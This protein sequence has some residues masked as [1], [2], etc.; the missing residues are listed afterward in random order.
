MKKIMSAF[1]VAVFVGNNK[2]SNLEDFLSDFVKE[3]KV[4]RENGFNYQGHTFNIDIL[5][6]LCDA[7]A[8]QFLKC[9][10]GHTGY[11]AC[12][13]CLVEGDYVSSRVIFP[14]LNC[15]L[16]V[17]ES[18][19]N[20]EY[21]GTHQIKKTVLIDAGIN[22]VKQFPLDYMHLVC[23]GVMKRLMLSWTEG[24]RQFKLSPR[25]IKQ[26]S[27]KLESFKGKL[28]TDFVR[29]PRGLDCLRRWK[30]TEFRQFLLYTGCVALKDVLSHDQYKN[31]ICFSVGMSILLEE[32]S[33]VRNELLTYAKDLLKYFVS[34]CT[35]LYGPAFTV[36]NV[37]SL[38]H[39]WEDC[40]NFDTALD[41]IS[42]F[43]FENYL[44]VVK[45]FVRKTKNP[46]SQ[47]VKRISELEKYS[48]TGTSQ[49]CLST[50]I[51]E[52]NQD[53]WFLLRSGEFAQ[54][55]SKNMDDSYSCNVVMKHH[56]QSLFTEPC[57]SK[58]FNVI[59]IQN[60]NS[61]SIHK[62]IQRTKLLRKAL[63]LPYKDGFMI[64]PMLNDIIYT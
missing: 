45:K 29:Q 12:E 55:K 33:N 19:K 22:C 39:L 4:L 2:P 28:P 40:R 42:S 63:C 57:D 14:Y 38:I 3:Y 6:F 49:K 59:Y 5:A 62:E 50:K 31:F 46:L 16:R 10:K 21:L 47:I 37:H 17:D 64:R 36:Y 61:V 34:S 54:I 25:Q 27:D 23:L 15:E 11:H 9:I 41:N 58:L 1:I 60:I 7:P 20:V 35:D 26:V 24:T 44:Q 13:R 43:P 56:H 53:S 18:F 32:N 52:N 8:R 48:M 51:S 30:A